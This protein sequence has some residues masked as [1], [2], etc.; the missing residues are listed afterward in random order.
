MGKREDYTKCMIPHMKG[1][2]PDRKLR[3]C[4][5]AKICSGK[6]STEEEAKRVCS[7]PKEPKPLK[8]KRKG[9]G[10]QSCEKGV[11]EISHCIVEHIDMDKASN[12]NS[13][14]TAIVNAMVVCQCP[15]K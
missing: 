15:Q 13:I 11:L 7:L 14:E 1:G 5:G 10:S 2:G 8:G 9:D 6:A 12:I 3:F 4:M